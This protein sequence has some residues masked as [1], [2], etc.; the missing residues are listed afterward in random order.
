MGNEFN[1]NLNIDDPLAEIIEAENTLRE[2][3]AASV[4]MEFGAEQNEAVTED[5]AKAEEAHQL[6]EHEQL[7]Q[8]RIAELEAQLASQ[9][10]LNSAGT[11]QATITSTGVNDD[12]PEVIDAEPVLVEAAGVGTDPNDDD[13]T[14]AVDADDEE[15]DTVD[16]TV[17]HGGATSGEGKAASD[18]D[19]DEPDWS[20]LDNYL[21]GAEDGAATPTPEQPAAPTE[22]Q[23]PMVTLQH[24]IPRASVN[25]WDPPREDIITVKVPKASI[26]P[27]PAQPYTV[28]EDAI[29][30][31]DGVTGSYQVASTRPMLSENT[32]YV[33][34][35]LNSGTRPGVWF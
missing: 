19:A 31:P 18:N 23:V 14:D 7:L 22:P 9:K 1:P 15:T 26:F 25:A 20:A 21:E 12:C 3:G 11:T 29:T 2:F 33:N 13:D 28:A 6:T 16:A 5:V 4:A 10:A 35:R 8:D 24:H 30:L 17:N 32:V 27:N 34:W